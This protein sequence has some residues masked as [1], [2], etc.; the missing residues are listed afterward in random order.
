MTRMHKPDP[1]LPTDQQDKRS[2]IVDQWL[3]GTMD[4]ARQLMRLTPVE[5]FNAEPTT[6]AG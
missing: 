2:V 3:A 5:I 1:K 6:T 4:E